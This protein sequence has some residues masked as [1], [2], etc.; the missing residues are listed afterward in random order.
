MAKTQ[1]KTPLLF[2]EPIPLGRYLLFFG[3]AILG[4]ATDL[5]TK[6]WAFE[7]RGMPGQ[8]PEWWLIQGY[9]GIET[10]LNPG[11]LFGMGKGYSWVFASLSVV[12]G[13]GILSWLFLFG[14]ARDRWLTIALGCVTAGILGNLYDRLGLWHLSGVPRGYEAYANCVRDWILFRYRGDIRWTWPNFNIADSLLVGGAI[15]LV[16]HAAW[17]KDDKPAANTTTK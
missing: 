8:Q 17:Q 10:S 9:V 14:A 15:M 4:A 1:P 2:G 5:L 7:W 3:I 16:L 12:A 6:E 13:L 11:A